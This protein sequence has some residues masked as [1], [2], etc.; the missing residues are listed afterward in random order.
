[1]SEKL[2]K[3]QALSRSCFDL[4]ATDA[5]NE[6]AM[7][8]GGYLKMLLHGRCSFDC[9]YCGICQREKAESFSPHE[10]ASLICCLYETKRVKG[11]FLSTGIPRDCGESMD[12]LL[13][14]ATLLRRGG[15]A[16]Y[17]HLK[18][19]PGA[20]RTD[21]NEAARL[22]D[23]ISI[24]LE[25]V[26]QERLSLIASV[27]N[28]E[29]DLLRRHAWVAEAAPGR[30]TTQIVVGAAEE[31]DSEIL[32]FM[33][34][35]YG[36]FAPA[37]IYYSGFT[38]LPDTPLAGAAPADPARLKGLYAA[39]ALIRDYGYSPDE[40]ALCL[41]EDGDLLPGDPKINAAGSIRI[42]PSSA[43]REEL[44]R[45]PGIGPKAAER[46]ISMRDAGEPVTETMLRNAGVVM[47]RAGAYL[48]IG[49]R[50]QVRL[51]SLT[52]TPASS[53]G[54]SHHPRLLR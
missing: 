27:K 41:N 54:T 11:L 16:G 18:V 39:D 23:R 12:D 2:R 52:Y 1:M 36:R 45:V 51:P 22:A 14:C 25:A 37:G 10:L 21:I 9:A 43:T 19:V 3:L 33:H 38:P 32:S 7:V 42:D 49:G 44:I 26:S 50:V 34:R 17:L 46:V 29:S 20:L 47:R 48:V 13:A 30:H 35:E 53:T 15:F 28:F 6:A 40:T 8:R 24:N 31:T 5:A 4:A